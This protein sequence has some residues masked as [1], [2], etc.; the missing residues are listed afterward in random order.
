MRVVETNPTRV[1]HACSGACSGF[2]RHFFHAISIAMPVR[3]HIVGFP[4]AT[5]RHRHVTV[6]FLVS[7]RVSHLDTNASQDSLE[8]R[9][10]MEGSV[11]ARSF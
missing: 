5:Q 2:E 6:P 9:G 11:C 3:E 10:R 1:V 4:R 8:P 7:N